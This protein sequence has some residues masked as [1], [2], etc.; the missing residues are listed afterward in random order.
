MSIWANIRNK[1]LGIENRLENPI[2]FR[3]HES[4]G[5]ILYSFSKG[6]EV[7]FNKGTHKECVGEFVGESRIAG[8]IF[9]LVKGYKSYV[10]SSVSLGE[11]NTMRCFDVTFVEQL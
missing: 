5:V 4:C 2:Y 9:K 6:E 7:T 8:L 11:N 1:S 3:I 10:E